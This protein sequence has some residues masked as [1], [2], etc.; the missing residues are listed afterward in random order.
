[1]SYVLHTDP[2]PVVA[3]IRAAI[4]DQ[5]HVMPPSASLYAGL[6]MRDARMVFLVDLK[7]W[8][9]QLEVTYQGK[10]DLGELA[11]E[12]LLIDIEY[13]HHQKEIDRDR[14]RIHGRCVPR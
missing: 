11:A 12:C 2:P 8:R 1:M 3:T 13:R 9:H 4:L 5:A 10:P 6:I 7:G 14:I